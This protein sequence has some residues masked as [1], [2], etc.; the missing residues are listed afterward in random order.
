[1][2]DGTL[3]RSGVL[4]AIGIT[5]HNLPEGIAV[6][7]GYEH[8]PQLGLLLATA[9]AIH[10]IPEGMATALPVYEAGASR[11]HV[12]SLALI[13]GMAEPVGALLA[14]L[15]LESIPKVV[16]VG[17]ALAAG[18]MVAITV[19]ELISTG[20]E[21]AR[22]ARRGGRRWRHGS[23][24]APDEAFVGYGHEHSVSVGPLMG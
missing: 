18:V 8:F 12:I 7:L 15:L 22:G 10:N 17:L 14:T 13:S 24:H 11:L 20:L 4:I 16:S 23:P 2:V 21:M 6:A 1:M 3:L 5:L 19:D 9:I